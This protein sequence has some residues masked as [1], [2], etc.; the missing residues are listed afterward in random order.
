M[1]EKLVVF[2]RS[3]SWLHIAGAFMANTIMNCFIPMYYAALTGVL[4]GIISETKDA[5]YEHPKNYRKNLADLMTWV[6]GSGWWLAV[7]AYQMM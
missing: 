2:F 5:I 3:R 6:I 1:F 4:I 7:K